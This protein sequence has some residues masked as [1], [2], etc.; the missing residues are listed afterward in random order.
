MTKPLVGT[1]EQ[2]ASRLV[3]LDPLHKAPLASYLARTCP[4]PA[5]LEQGVR[6]ANKVVA[7]VKSV[8][9]SSFFAAEYGRVFQTPQAALSTRTSLIVMFV[10][11]YGLPEKQA[12]KMTDCVVFSAAKKPAVGTD[13]MTKLASAALKAGVSFQVVADVVY[14]S[15]PDVAPSLFAQRCQ[16]TS[17]KKHKEMAITTAKL[18]K[19][20]EASIA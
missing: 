16:K 18:T 1:K 5:A 12:A 3:G 6:Q 14:Y 9:V 11:E 20:L 8:R 13:R 7:A 4:S 19:A 15:A 17:D 10:F 2:I